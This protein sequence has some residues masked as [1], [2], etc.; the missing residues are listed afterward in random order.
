MLTQH[1][2]TA[3]KYNTYSISELEFEADAKPKSAKA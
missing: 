3:K 1:R 2:D